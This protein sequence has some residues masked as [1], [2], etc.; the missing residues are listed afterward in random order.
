LAAGAVNCIDVAAAANRFGARVPG[1]TAGRLVI[2][3]G[4]LQFYAAPDIGC[5]MQ[6]VAIQ[7]GEQVDALIESNGFTAVKYRRAATGGEAIGWVP[8]HRLKPNGRGSVPPA[9]L[10]KA[11]PP[12]VP[13]AKAEAPVAVARPAAPPATPPATPAKAE[14]PSVASRPAPPPPVAVA[15]AEPPAMP[16]ARLAPPVPV[17]A[18]P[19]APPPGSAPVA[20]RPGNCKE[21]DVA[22]ARAGVA[23]AARSAGRKVVGAGRLQFYAAPDPLCRMEGT[24]ILSGEPVDAFYEFSDFTSVRYRHPHTGVETRGWVSS[25]RLQADGR[26]LTPGP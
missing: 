22:A 11:E 8:A 10:A 1:E 14:P 24:F 17:E 20:V 13:A 3:S 21:A 19:A 2:G 7:S 6:G 9:A 15:K 4:R 12:A 18:R 16:P 25:K 23:V 5:E 26:G